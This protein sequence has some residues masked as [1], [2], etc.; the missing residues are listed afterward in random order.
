MILVTGDDG[1]KVVT[2]TPGG[3]FSDAA[4]KN[5]NS[6]TR[7]RDV[8]VKPD[9]ALA[10]VTTEEGNLFLVDLFPGG[11]FDVISNVNTGSRARNAE[12]SPDALFVY[13]TLTDPDEVAVYRIDYGGSGI[14]SGSYP[15][16]ITLSYH[17]TIPLG[18]DAEPKALVID[19]DAEVL[20]VIHSDATNNKDALSAFRICCGPI[21]ADKTIGDMIMNIQNLVRSG[22]IDHQNG[23]PLIS[24]L[25]EVIMLLDE[26]ETREAINVLNTFIRKVERMFKKDQIP[27]DY[28][29]DL[30]NQ[31]KALIGKINAIIAVLELEKKSAYASVGANEINLPDESSLGPIY[32]NP[33]GQSTT[34]KY[35]V[36]TTDGAPVRVHMSVINSTGQVVAHLVDQ[37]KEPGS[38]S[39]EWDARLPDDRQVADGV[40]YVRFTAGQAQLV[41][42]LFVI[43]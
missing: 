33:F 24:K 43:R 7:T 27:Y 36:S 1:L 5:V 30:I 6:G 39:V 14:P 22:I 3:D 4:I 10:I 42:K 32:P 11:N 18:E 29:E 38:Y 35:A 8:T 26:G 31:A 28:K 19:P 41:E 21:P 2:F 13:V 17:N 9:I 23:D 20:A 15:Q 40:Y 12:I 25:Y 16:D 37:V 34:I